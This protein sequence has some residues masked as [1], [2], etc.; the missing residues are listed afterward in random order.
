MSSHRILVVEDEGLIAADIASRLEGLGHEV[1]GAVGTAEE[2][3]AKAGE[4]DLVLM[5]IRLDGQ[6]DGVQAATE[7]RDRFRVPVVFLTGQSDRATIERAKVAQPFGYIVKP[8]AAAVLHTNIEIAINRHRV[9]R[10]LEERE[11]WLRTTLVSV[12]DA[13]IVTSVDGRVLMLNRAAEV[14]TGWIQ[15]EAEGRPVSK[16]IRLVQGDSDADIGEAVALAMLRDAP[17]PMDP[18]CKL[19]SRSGRELWIEGAAGP[20]KEDGITLGTVITL[21]DVSARGWE[22]RQLRQSERLEAVCRLASG[23]SND[24][25][26][27]LD[28]IRNK[29]EHLLRQLDEYS[30]V[31]KAV[32]EIQQAADTADRIT[33]RLAVLGT[34]QMCQPEVVSLNSILR[35]SAKLIESIAGVGV[36]VTIRTT[37]TAGRINAD[38]VRIK[39][40]IMSLTRHACATMPGGGRLLIETADTEIPGRGEATSY[41]LL[42]ITY[43]GEEADPE[44]LFEPASTGEEGFALSMVHAIV[45][46]HGG[47][48]SAQ[49][50]VGG[51]CRFE[52]LLPRVVG[53]LLLP[54]PPDGTLRSILLVDERGPIR[55]QL[56][57]FFEANGYN[58][59][60]AADPLEAMAIGAVHEG[61]VDLLIAETDSVGVALRELHPQMGILKIVDWPE[62]KA[63]EI[64]RPF[65]QQAL[66]ERVQRKFAANGNGQ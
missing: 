35:L 34:R 27:L 46:E 17:V 7:I 13:V 20:V 54:A 56:H 66:L 24:Y 21:R 47:Y 3:L 60:E 65:T 40:A 25:S 26:H 10:R 42:A 6:R 28:V 1:I 39:E 55:A 29:A 5:D 32:E 59:L 16:V 9:E 15:P 43:T 51:G 52:M 44:K 4:A 58:L 37:P 14:L 11:S 50:T 45:T 49:A 33:R 12:A 22:E 19:V 62:S 53:R 31:R 8:M 41:A 61:P 48:I 57:N 18:S 2:A 63:D 36:D 23:I 38:A 64:Q 30:P